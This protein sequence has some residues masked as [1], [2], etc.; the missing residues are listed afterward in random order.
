[1]NSRPKLPVLDSKGWVTHPPEML[2]SL[3][4]Y[5]INAESNQSDFFGNAVRALKTDIAAFNQSEF[6][7]KNNV[8]TSLDIIF[9]AWFPEGV[10][11]DVTVAP[12]SPDK[13]NMLNVSAKVTVVADGIRH[14]LGYQVSL[15][16]GNVNRY[17][18]MQVS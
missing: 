5:Y 13:P 14:D 12:V 15:L 17:M 1:M 18:K 16:N 2:D 7:L 6:T 11:I 10:E 3:M 8:T 4:S 9:S